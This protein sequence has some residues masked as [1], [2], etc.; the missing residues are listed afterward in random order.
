MGV[1]SDN[2]EGERRV[3]PQ[4]GEERGR[5]AKR[6]VDFPYYNKAVFHL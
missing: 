6:A 4:A 5:Y 1:V 2:V 3:G